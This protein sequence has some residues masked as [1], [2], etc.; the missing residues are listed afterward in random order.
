[1]A[2]IAEGVKLH[3]VKADGELV[4]TVDLGGYDLSKAMARAELMQ[5]IVDSLTPS[6]FEP[7]DSDS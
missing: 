6:C 5:T 7:V 1:M 3:I 2:K 4:E